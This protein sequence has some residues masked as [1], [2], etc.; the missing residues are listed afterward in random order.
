MSPSASQ[1]WESHKHLR[2][3]SSHASSPGQGL[4]PDSRSSRR[5]ARPSSRLW[6]T[7]C[8]GPC[9][10]A[11]LKRFCEVSRTAVVHTYTLLLCSDWAHGLRQPFKLSG[12]VY[13]LPM[14]TQTHPDPTVRHKS[15]AFDS[16]EMG[17][18]KIVL[19]KQ[20][21]C[22]GKE[23]SLSQVLASVMFSTD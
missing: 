1:C 6:W 18:L 19:Y 2:C 20:R 21:E 4:T 13:T 11:S 22:I 10:C 3:K 14:Y 15:K 7:L 9:F 17:G 23:E 8:A 16:F 5:A 12:S